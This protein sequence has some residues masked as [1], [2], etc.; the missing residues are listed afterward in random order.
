MLD[1]PAS[2]TGG[3]HSGT[4][5]TGLGAMLGPMSPTA[6]GRRVLCLALT[7]TE[8]PLPLRLTVIVR[9]HLSQ[10]QKHSPL[11]LRFDN[12]TSESESAGFGEGISR[13]NNFPP[14]RYLKTAPQE[15][16]AHFVTM[17][18]IPKQIS[19]PS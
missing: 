12:R 18:S 19:N 5:E 8:A 15:G 17:K 16:F 13:R 2:M 3:A 9:A 6:H 1:R 11:D 7:M 4:N 10:S 14:R